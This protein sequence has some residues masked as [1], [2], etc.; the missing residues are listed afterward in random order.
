MVTLVGLGVA[1][2]V[3]ATPPTTWGP[4]VPL[5][6][7]NFYPQQTK[8]TIDDSGTATAVWTGGD[9]FYDRSIRTSTQEAGGP[10]SPPVTLADEGE[11]P[12]LAGNGAG[13]AVTA[14]EAYDGAIHASTRVA[15]GPWSAPTT[16]SVGADAFQK[17]SLPHVAIN[18][19]GDVVAVWQQRESPVPHIESARMAAGGA[20]SPP[21]AIGSNFLE[22]DLGP[23]IA[24]DASGDAVAAW[25]VE[26][27]GGTKVQAATSVGAAWTPPVDLD[28]A[29]DET[30]GW[31]SVAMDD[32]GDAVVAWAHFTDP[33]AGL[34]SAIRPAAGAWSA[35]SEVDPGPVASPPSIASDAMGNATAVWSTYTAEGVVVTS[36]QRST[37]TSWAAAVALSTPGGATL[38]PSPRVT[39]DRSG[40][41]AAVWEQASESPVTRG[42]QVASRTV[43]TARSTPHIVSLPDQFGNT[44]EVAL[45]DDGDA[46]VSYLD[47]DSVDQSYAA[48]AVRSPAPAM[49]PPVAPPVMLLP[50]FTG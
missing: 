25:V 17:A 46:V 48:W 13:D 11:L 29:P 26:V 19:A 37:N 44:P 47:N 6:G 7:T 4:P 8:V 50:R 45:S 18:E 2:P 3:G 39:A 35:S 38:G 22:N 33:D 10:W 41:V 12:V 15:G 31:P 49:A 23:D 30:A 43:D 28:A 5:S 36:A 14:W 24:N 42:I 32:G 34:R 27:S 1:T 16:L 40:D 9:T 20:W 21:V